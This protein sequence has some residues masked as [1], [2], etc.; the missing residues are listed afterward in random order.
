[1]YKVQNQEINIK[2]V[3]LVE[4]KDAQVRNLSEK[5]DS[6]FELMLKAISDVS[7]QRSVEKPGADS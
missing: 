1:M 7:V 3:K 5:I 2:L 4:D 6:K